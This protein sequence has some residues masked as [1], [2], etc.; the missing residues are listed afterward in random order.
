MTQSTLAKGGE[1]CVRGPFHRAS[2]GP[3]QPPRGGG[4]GALLFA[5]L[6]TIASPVFAKPQRVVSLNLCADEL[7]LRLADP[8]VV[9]S[10]TWISQDPLNANLAARA[11]ALPANDGHVEE[12]LAYDPDLVL[13]GPFADPASIALLKQVGAPV[14]QVSAPRSLDGVRGEIRHVAAALGEP[15][16]GEALVA[17]MDARL[18]RVAVDPSQPRLTTIVLQPN[19]FTVGPGSLVDEILTRAGLDNLAARR[20]DIAADAEVPLEVVASLEPDVLILDRSEETAPSLAEAALDHP[21]IQALARRMT[22]VSLPARLWTCGGPEITEAVERLA[23]VAAAA[24][25]RR[26]TP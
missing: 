14:V 4:W 16:R 23:A 17:E 1:N 6:V 19:G 26:A 3:P 2:R 11:A 10:V 15:Q 21:A 8:G 13:V 22:I 20:L 5:A 7:A 18:A 24:R 25:A 9:K 12:A